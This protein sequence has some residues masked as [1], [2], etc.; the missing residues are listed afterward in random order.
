MAPASLKET[1][2]VDLQ[3][4]GRWLNNRAESSHFP[5]RRRERAMLRFRRMRSL[6]KFDSGHAYVY[7][8][9]N[10][11]R[12]LSSRDIFK[13]NR[14]SAL[15]GWRGLC[16]AQGAGILPLTRRV[17][18]RLTEQAQAPSSLSRPRPA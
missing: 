18:M 13:A 14:A 7:R 2:A 17:R 1:G 12:G 11:G 16:A 8:N 15:T 6:Q 10:H 4:T 3:L 9:F 5:F